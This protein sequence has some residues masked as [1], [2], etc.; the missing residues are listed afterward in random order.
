MIWQRSRT[1]ATGKGWRRVKGEHMYAAGKYLD[2]E[3]R[4]VDGATRISDEDRAAGIS[5]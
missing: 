3:N 2:A 4:K 5:S 1:D